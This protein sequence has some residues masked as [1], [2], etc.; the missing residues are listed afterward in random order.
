MDH[1]A[2]MNPKWHLIEKILSGEKTIESRWYVHRIA[3]WDKITPGDTVYF[4]NSGKQVTAKAT[5]QKV[6]QMEL[7]SL[8]STVNIVREFQSKICLTKES[9]NDFTWL[10]KKRYAILIFLKDPQVVTPFTVNKQGYGSACAWI[11]I[12]SIEALKQ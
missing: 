9:L 4:K 1:I 10:E 6:M 2:I 3:P 5:V 8:Q 7:A 12:P 11:S